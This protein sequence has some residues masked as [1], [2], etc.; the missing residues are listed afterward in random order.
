MIVCAILKKIKI[1][2]YASLYL[3]QNKDM[4]KE[5]AE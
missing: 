3:L 5:K 2:E 4:K 1:V